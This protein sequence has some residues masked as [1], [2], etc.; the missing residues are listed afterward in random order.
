MAGSQRLR[1]NPLDAGEGVILGGDWI[2][3]DWPSTLEA[4]TR[5]GLTAAATYL[6]LNGVR[7]FTGW[8]H[9]DSW[10]D[11][12]NSPNRGDKDWRVWK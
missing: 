3:I 8:H 2:N 5:S 4:S 1:P 11:W 9:D 12:P 6:E 10:L 7:D